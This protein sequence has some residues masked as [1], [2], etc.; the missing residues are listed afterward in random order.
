MDKLNARRIIAIVLSP[1]IIWGALRLGEKGLEYLGRPSGLSERE[2]V[3][4][5][6][7]LIG[8]SIEIPLEHFRIG[9]CPSEY[10][11]G[12][13]AGIDEVIGLIRKQPHVIDVASL[14]SWND[15]SNRYLI[16]MQCLGGVTYLELIDFQK[17]VDMGE[18]YHPYR[19]K[20]SYALFDCSVTL[21]KDEEYYYILFPQIRK[22]ESGDDLLSGADL[23]VDTACLIQKPE[24]SSEQSLFD[25]LLQF[26]KDSALYEVSS[27]TDDEIIV[28]F[29]ENTLKNNPSTIPEQDST[30]D[31]A[32]KG[33]FKI[34]VDEVVEKITITLL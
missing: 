1:F 18:W 6:P 11:F 13:D 4:Y 10:H 25:F 7:F 34:S 16:T 15:G 8:K 3:E 14:G 30:M 32:Y 22:N 33:A 21:E 5:S 9:D 27:Y 2:V 20:H 24:N 29:N 23:K 12:A 31:S 26:Y 19:S 28:S 17:S